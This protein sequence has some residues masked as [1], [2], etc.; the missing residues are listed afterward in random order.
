MVTRRKTCVKNEEL[1]PRIKGTCGFCRYASTSD[2][3]DDWIYCNMWKT[4]G[5]Q[6]ISYCSRFDADAPDVI[7]QDE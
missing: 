1:L 5:L 2:L 4:D 6:R 7:L 3:H